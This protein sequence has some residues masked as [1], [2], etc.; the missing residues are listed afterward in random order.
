VFLK[1]H[2]TLPKENK[3]GLIKTHHYL[4]SKSTY[5]K[6]EDHILYIYFILFY[7]I[8]RLYSNMFCS[9][10]FDV[11]KMTMIVVPLVKF[12]LFCGSGVVDR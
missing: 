10:L 7:I 3:I 11:D 2:G 6:T 4:S 12:V 1:S 9:F 5:V 8:Y